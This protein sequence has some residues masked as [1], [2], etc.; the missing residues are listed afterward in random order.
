[1]AAKLKFGQKSAISPDVHMPFF[2]NNFFHAFFFTNVFIETIPRDV[3]RFITFCY[4]E[5]SKNGPKVT[6]PPK[7]TPNSYMISN[8]FSRI[9]FFFARG[10]I[11]KNFFSENVQCH[12]LDKTFVTDFEIFANKIFKKLIKND[13]FNYFLKI[14]LAKIPKSATKVLSRT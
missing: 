2:L 7:M 12:V 13:N 11:L 3:F 10:R 1:M 14:L 6:L 9:I 4:V 5:V 8:A